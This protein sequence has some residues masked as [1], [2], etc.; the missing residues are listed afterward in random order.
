[1]DT[2]YYSVFCDGL[3]NAFLQPNMLNLEFIKVRVNRD[4]K[5]NIYT[6]KSLTDETQFDYSS[7]F[8]II[9]CTSNYKRKYI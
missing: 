8:I 2:I 4:N 1:M 9:N 5:K 6:P 3:S 7:T